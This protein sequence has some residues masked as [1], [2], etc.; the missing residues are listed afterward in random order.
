MYYQNPFKWHFL[1]RYFIIQNFKITNVSNQWKIVSDNPKLIHLCSYCILNF[2]MWLD[3]YLKIFQKLPSVSYNVYLIKH[4]ECMH[5]HYC[6]QTGSKRPWKCSHGTNSFIQ[7]K[8]PFL[9]IDF[10]NHL[11]CTS[12]KV[13]N[14]PKT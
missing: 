3:L 14:D 10:A 11:S 1:V 13:K 7:L 6:S 2:Q 12:K 5:L 8:V 9:S 4:T